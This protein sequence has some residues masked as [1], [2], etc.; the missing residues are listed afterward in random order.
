MIN[1]YKIFSG[2]SFFRF[3]ERYI[4]LNALKRKVRKNKV[5][6]IFLH[7]KI[8]IDVVKENFCEKWNRIFNKLKWDV[9]FLDK[10]SFDFWWEKQQFQK[11]QNYKSSNIKNKMFVFITDKHLAR[12]IY[13]IVIANT[14]KTYLL[15]NPH[16]ILD[17]KQTNSKYLFTSS[18]FEIN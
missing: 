5:V 3:R 17:N 9:I 4:S 16:Q 10:E 6:L 11:K 18:F 15:K 12:E 2:F 1:V 7:P 13:R 14:P 8:D